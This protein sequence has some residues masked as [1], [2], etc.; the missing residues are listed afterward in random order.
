MQIAGEIIFHKVLGNKK[1][2]SP[3]GKLKGKVSL[4][5]IQ[6]KAMSTYWALGVMMSSGNSTSVLLTVG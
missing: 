2:L 1:D 5:L 3:R 4:A 6:R